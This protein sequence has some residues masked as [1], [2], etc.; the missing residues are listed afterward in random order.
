MSVFEWPLKT[1]FT[2]FD[3]HNYFAVYLNIMSFYQTFNFA[4][5]K[6]GYKVVIMF[7]CCCSHCIG[8]CFV[9]MLCVVTVN[10]EIFARTLFSRMA[11]KDIFTT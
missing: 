8:G 5:Y 6:N 2:V 10:P 3:T 11:L 4:C 1:G 7:V 9:S